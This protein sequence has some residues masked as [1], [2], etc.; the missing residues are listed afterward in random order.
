MNR[1]SIDMEVFPLLS[2]FLA[3]VH[4]FSTNRKAL[5]ELTEFKSD[6][7][8]VRDNVEEYE[9][10]TERNELDL[11]LLQM[12]MRDLSRAKILEKYY[13]L[14][15]MLDEVRDGYLIKHLD[16]LYECISSAVW[17][18]EIL[19]DIGT[20]IRDLID[21]IK[22]NRPEPPFFISMKQGS[23]AINQL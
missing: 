21:E 20:V 23:Q 16:I 18:M 3:E 12:D 19:N 10:L 4:A 17:D 2:S 5:C 7:K 13:N 8:T 6:I 22:L 9:N 11:K 1:T 14:L 15:L